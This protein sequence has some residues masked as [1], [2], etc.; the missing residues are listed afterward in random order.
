MT[1][2]FVSQ[3]PPFVPIHPAEEA[4]KLDGG[5][6][7]GEAVRPVFGESVVFGCGF[8]AAGSDGQLHGNIRARGLGV[9]TPKR[10]QRFFYATL[11]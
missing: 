6:A 7:T 1:A 4:G 8:K 2:K 3:S 11:A 5:G 9:V 10:S